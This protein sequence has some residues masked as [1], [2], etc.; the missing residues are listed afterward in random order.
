MKYSRNEKLLLIV[1][2]MLATLSIIWIF[3]SLIFG[4][5]LMINEKFF[6]FPFIISILSLFISIMYIC[7][8]PTKNKEENKEFIEKQSSVRD[9]YLYQQ[10]LDPPDL[11]N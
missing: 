1:W 9:Y 3:F 6:L 5:N 10:L 7:R 4:L 2:L 8:F 11:N